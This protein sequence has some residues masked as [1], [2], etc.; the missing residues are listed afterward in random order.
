V[1]SL[2]PSLSTGDRYSPS[3]KLGKQK[4]FDD[5]VARFFNDLTCLEKA[6]SQ[7]GKLAEVG[8]RL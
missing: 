3:R 7:K 8:V 1:D 6:H 5:L 2:R 4:V